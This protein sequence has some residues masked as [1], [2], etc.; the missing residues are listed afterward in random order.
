MDCEIHSLLNCSNARKSDRSG[1]FT[2]ESESIRT[3]NVRIVQKVF[4]TRSQ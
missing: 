3:G 1:F 2:V 4:L